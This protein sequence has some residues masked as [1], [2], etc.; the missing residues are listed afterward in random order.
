MSK[1]P[2]GSSRLAMLALTTSQPNH[3][4]GHKP[5]VT[6]HS[7]AYERRASPTSGL[8]SISAGAENRIQPRSAT[9]AKSVCNIKPG[10][11][12]LQRNPDRLPVAARSRYCDRREN[13][14]GIVEAGSGKDMGEFPLSSIK[15]RIFS[16]LHF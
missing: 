14:R 10:L 12:L 16:P 7:P 5:L 3:R 15:Q 8:T 4:G 6:G 13:G 1:P 2:C 9:S 11:A